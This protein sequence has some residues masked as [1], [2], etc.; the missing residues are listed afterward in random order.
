M[1]RS[2]FLGLIFSGPDLFPAQRE[3]K[4]QKYLRKLKSPL[5]LLLLPLF[6]GKKTTRRN[7]P[8][9]V[10][11]VMNTDVHF[12]R[13]LYELRLYKFKMKGNTL[14][15]GSQLKSLYSQSGEE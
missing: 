12:S 6:G 9:V 8:F 10:L 15:A 7:F 5:G 4:P 13:Q 14:L 2:K 1:L 11:N 3:G